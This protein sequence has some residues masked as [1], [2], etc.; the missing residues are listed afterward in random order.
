MKRDVPM[1]GLVIGLLL[2]FLGVFI[3]YLLWGHG[4]GF[5]NFLHSL[6]RLKDLAGKVF[7]LGLLINLAPFLYCMNKHYDHTMR[8]IVIATVLYAVLIVLI[9]YV[10]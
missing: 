8:G 10:W 3:M 4:A 5:G 2:P 1:V 6:T 9:K 7:T